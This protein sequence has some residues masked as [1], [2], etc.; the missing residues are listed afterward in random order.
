MIKNKTGEAYKVFKRIANSNKKTDLSELETLN[1]E[2]EAKKKF[3]LNSIFPTS[4]T[5]I[6]ATQVYS[7]NKSVNNKDMDIQEDLSIF[8][9]IDVPKSVRL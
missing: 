3:N 5:A 8:E 9:D 2:A 1:A 6:K 4:E 7:E